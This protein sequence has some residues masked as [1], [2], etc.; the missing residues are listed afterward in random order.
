MLS[1]ENYLPKS[2][3]PRETPTT[4]ETPSSSHDL[5]QPSAF[6]KRCHSKS[7]LRPTVFR[8]AEV[9]TS[10]RERIRVEFDLDSHTRP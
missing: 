4:P 5:C 1:K 3:H 8:T 9:V 2:S 7:A 6:V 10:E